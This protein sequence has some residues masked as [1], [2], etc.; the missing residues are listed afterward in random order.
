MNRP[1]RAGERLLPDDASPPNR[2]IDPA[3]RRGGGGDGGGRGPGPMPRRPRYGLLRRLAGAGLGVLVLAVAVAS[4]VAWRAWDHFSAD[5]PTVAGLQDYHPP[6]M[7]RVYDTDDTLVDEFASERRIFVPYAAIPDVVKNAFIAAEDQ[8]FWTHNGVDP[9]AI[10]RAAVTDLENIHSGRR[11]IGASTITQQVAKNM[12]LG[13]VSTFSTKIKEAILA[14]RMERTLPKEKILEI[15]LNEIYLGLGSYGIAAAAQTYFDKPLDQLTIAEAAFLGALPKGPNN[16]NPYRFPQAALARRDWVLDRM[17]DTRAITADEARAAKAAPLVPA[18]VHRAPVIPGADWFTE[19]VRRQLVARFGPDQVDAGGLTVETSLDPR[20]QGDATDALRAGLLNYERAHGLWRGPVRH[21]DVAL[22]QD[23]GGRP[24][25]GHARAAAPDGDAASG[26][27]WARALTDVKRPPGMLPAWTLGVVL[28]ETASSARIGWL[29]EPGDALG[30]PAASHVSVMDWSDASWARTARGAPRQMSDVAK[31]GDVLEVELLDGGTAHEH[32]ALRQVPK[33]EGALV[34]LDPVS[35]RVRAL[36]GGWSTEN[37]QFNR[38]TQAERQPGSS[39]KPIVYLAAM[40][41]GISPSQEFLDGPFAMGNWRP[42]NYEMD[43]N[44]MTT[45]HDA[46]RQSLNLVTIRL[47]AHI[48]MS[49]VADLAVAMHEVDAMPKVLP[50][51][52]GAVDTT[53]LREAGAYATIAEGG[54]LVEPSLID[55]VQDR[56]GKVLW[57][58]SGTSVAAGDTDGDAPPPL[59]DTRKSVADPDSAFQV[60]TMMEDVVKRGTGTPAAIGID[61]PIA[62]KTGTS[63]DF[64]DA[65]FVGFTP[66]LVTA[67]WV[68]FD[69][70][71]SLGDKET[72]GAVAGPIW[73]AFTKKAL[74]TSPAKPFRVPDGI[75]LAD[76]N[77]GMGY[78]VDAFKA[79]QVPGSSQGLGAAA[80]SDL[81]LGPQDTGSELDAAIPPPE[82]GTGAAAQASLGRPGAAGT[83]PGAPRAAAPGGGG[84]TGGGGG[85][86]IG[87]GGLY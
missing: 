55:S 68:G 19:E 86:D 80:A 74:G 65:W 4:V 46:L 78:A 29:D 5:L 77:T 54:R 84:G 72:G 34:S 81:T 9:L 6:L 43:Y 41:K 12:I 61:R 15:Y 44:G 21:L 82:D 1:L 25:R 58:P 27:D 60:L 59:V 70:P 11:P 17:V 38:A 53:V 36:V 83:A 24:H 69:Q 28:S 2:P 3:R 35:G 79:G 57:T 76:Y 23:A 48:G 50:A 63:Q 20:L 87:V 51:A 67:V 30:P 22:P 14:M 26:L 66:E 42:E 8:N 49:S 39:F 18:G 73:N 75:T 52:L 62:G 64:N 40:M 32:M 71:A 31:P 10:A 45:L 16:Y 7:S 85:G 33:V 47:A 56:D 37:S 13:N